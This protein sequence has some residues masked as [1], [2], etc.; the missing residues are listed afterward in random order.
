MC[1]SIGHAA[2]LFTAALSFVSAVKLLLVLAIRLIISCAFAS[3]GKLLSLILAR[4]TAVLLMSL[5]KNG[6]NHLP[7][8]RWCVRAM[9]LSRPFQVALE[10]M[11]TFGLA[12]SLGRL[13]VSVSSSSLSV[14]LM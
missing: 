4:T 6:A 11:L 8:S 5:L 7:A 9:I 13:R 1:R 14:T 2:L 10:P 12:R 3:P